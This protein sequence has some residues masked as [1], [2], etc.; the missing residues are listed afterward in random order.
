ME[1]IAKAIDPAIKAGTITTKR[2][3][4]STAACRRKAFARESSQPDRL[5]RRQGRVR[6]HNFADYLPDTFTASL[7][8]RRWASENS[9]PT[10]DK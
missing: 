6:T 5:M 4:D 2:G 3:N 8:S 7:A 10:V 9:Q 1:S